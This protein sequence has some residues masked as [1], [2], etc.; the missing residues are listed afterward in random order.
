MTFLIALSSGVVIF[1]SKFQLNF[2]A[3]TWQSQKSGDISQCEQVCA[4]LIG[5]TR[6][7]T[8]VAV[9][10]TKVKGPWSAA[11]ARCQLPVLSRGHWR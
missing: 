7:G 3:V 8:E 2:V 11:P 10:S 4:S 5:G 1:F 9:P 6:R